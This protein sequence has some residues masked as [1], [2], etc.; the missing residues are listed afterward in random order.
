MG[1]PRC[2]G[3]MTEDCWVTDDGHAGIDRLCVNC[4]HRAEVVS[5]VCGA[6]PRPLAP[7]GCVEAYWLK[8]RHE[9]A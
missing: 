2:H 3:L 8:H 1:C 9:A 4:G 7:K 6:Q 5:R